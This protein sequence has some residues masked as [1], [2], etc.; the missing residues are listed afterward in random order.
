M[1]SLIRELAE[2]FGG[3]GAGPSSRISAAPS[4]RTTSAGPPDQTATSRSA[5]SS[6]AAS[7]NPQTPIL[8]LHVPA[9]E[10]Y[11]KHT[12]QLSTRAMSELS[13]TG[14]IKDAKVGMD[15]TMAKEAQSALLATVAATRVH[16]SG[17]V[18]RQVETKMEFVGVSE[19]KRLPLR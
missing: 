6:A 7:T 13:K 8:R 1:T 19:S 3:T 18:Q 11:R 15:A 17:T 14:P 2:A 5:S 10:P 12:E 16:S 9:G 4:I